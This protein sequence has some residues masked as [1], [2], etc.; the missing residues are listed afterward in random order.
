MNAN[1]SAERI[2]NVSGMS[3][4]RKATRI[5]NYLKSKKGRKITV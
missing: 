4:S 5:N 3:V 2:M 1:M